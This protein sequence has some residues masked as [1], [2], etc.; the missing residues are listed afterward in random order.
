MRNAVLGMALAMAA[1]LSLA[2]TAAAQMGETVKLAPP[3]PSV[4]NNIGIDQKL[5]A[6][7]PLE[8]SFKDEH[9]REV[10]LGDY[11]GKVPVVLA[12][13][14]YDCP[15]LCT[16]TLNGMVSAFSILKFDIGNQYQVVTVSF[17]PKEKP[18]LAL[19][20]KEAYVH[21]YGRAGAEQGWHF[22][23]GEPASIAA[24]T[25]AVGFRY[26]WDDQ[27]QQYAHATGLILLT[28][29]GRIAQYYYGVEFSPRDLRLGMVEAS[30]GHI[31]TL[32]DQVLLYCY[33][34]D[35]RTG[36]YGAVITRVLQIAGLITVAV[37]G[38]FLILMFK[39]E[40][41]RRRLAPDEV[42]GQRVA[43]H[44][45]RGSST[46]DAEHITGGKS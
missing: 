27:T 15:M 42:A 19:K 40:P 44:V 18:E 20:K 3:P 22:L 35:P 25:K 14:Y 33:H 36:K 21:R 45:W 17:D 24:L 16:E 11:F 30:Q 29:Q 9:G 5:N 28:P 6:Q 2:S 12:L 1:L 41:K 4:L 32:V 46:R 10:K 31:G 34:Y 43:P 26:Q 8:L 7:A 13:V 38:G 39:L 23:T 37:L